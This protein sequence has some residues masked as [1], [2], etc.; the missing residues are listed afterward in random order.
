MSLGKAV[1]LDRDGIINRERGFTYK[2][3]EFEILADV[4]PALVELKKRG[5]R[6]IIVSNQSGISKG[7]YTVEDVEMLHAHLVAHLKSS[8][9]VLDEVYY[10]VHHP[11]QTNCICRKPDSLFIEKAL[12]RF[13]LDAARCYFIGDKERDKEAAEKAGVKG[14][15]VEANT[16]LLEVI[17]L[18]D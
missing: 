1:F 18:I 4:S 11:E 13:S 2:L 8:G 3:E 6:L 10:C 9:I 7:L 5:Y 15:L 16:S 17:K 12:S 14:L